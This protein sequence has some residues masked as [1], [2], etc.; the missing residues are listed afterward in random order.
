MNDAKRVLVPDIL[1]GMSEVGT[2]W[3]VFVW[4]SRN[5]LF[6]K[7][8]ES[9]NTLV[10]T[11]C[12]RIILHNNLHWEISEKKQKIPKDKIQKLSTSKHNVIIKGDLL[13][14]INACSRLPIQ[15]FTI[16][17]WKIGIRTID[18]F[19]TICSQGSFCSYCIRS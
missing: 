15:R 19:C 13:F 3:L 16:I 7:S 10:S 4:S 14:S 8:E 6:V 18:T 17:K 11:A 5:E 9:W 1:L 12:W 2:M